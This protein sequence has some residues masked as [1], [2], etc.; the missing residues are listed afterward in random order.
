VFTHRAHYCRDDPGSPPGGRVADFNPVKVIEIQNATLTT[1]VPSNRALDDAPLGIRVSVNKRVYGGVG[2]YPTDP[3][4][5]VN[6]RCHSF[7]K[8]SSQ[9]FV[10]FLRD[11]GSSEVFF[12]FSSD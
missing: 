12:F 7:R 6:Q 1:T 5:L 9:R 11:E 2:E 10:F 4:L 3:K 8:A